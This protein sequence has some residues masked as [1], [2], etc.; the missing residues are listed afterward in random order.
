LFSD[1]PAYLVAVRCPL[2]V[3]EAREASRRDRTL[4]QARKQFAVVHVHVVYDLEV[5]T[6]ALSV[7]ECVQHILRHVDEA[8][9]AAFRRMAKRMAT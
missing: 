7:D 9:P 3:V 6:S 5:D 1:L 2:D 8:A 4:G